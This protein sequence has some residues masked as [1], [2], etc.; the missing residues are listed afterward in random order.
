MTATGRRLATCDAQMV[1]LRKGITALLRVVEAGGRLVVNDQ[2][3]EYRDTDRT[4]PF[5]AVNVGVRWPVSSSD[6]PPQP[7]APVRL[8]GLAALLEDEAMLPN[9]LADYLIDQGHGYATAVAE[10]AARDER[11]RIADRLYT[12]ASHAMGKGDEMNEYAA[13]ALSSVADG[14]VM[15][16]PPTA[17]KT[18]E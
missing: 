5:Y 2:D 17:P 16:I 7:L 10:K 14:L 3:D 4:I 1:E 9:A 12:E 6:P 15:G 8:L 13:A 18:A 11:E